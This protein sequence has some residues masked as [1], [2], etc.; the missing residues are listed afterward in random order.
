VPTDENENKNENV[1]VQ[2]NSSKLIQDPNQSSEE[3]TANTAQEGKP[4]FIQ[5]PII[6]NS[7]QSIL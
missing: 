6:F 5:M 2:L 7:M 3:P 1:E 4:R